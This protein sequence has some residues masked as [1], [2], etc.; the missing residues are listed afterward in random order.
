MQ[1][2]AALVTGIIALLVVLT[3]CAE[4]P[5]APEPISASAFRSLVRSDF[6]VFAASTDAQLTRLG[7]TGCKS[8]TATDEYGIPGTLD[9]YVNNQDL[10]FSKSDALRLMG[11]EASAYCPEMLAKLGAK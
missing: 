11:Y 9:T 7:H 8:M 10:G 2:Q 6:P 5:T 4:N 1:K 3:G